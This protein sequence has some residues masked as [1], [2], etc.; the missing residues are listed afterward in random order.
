MKVATLFL[1]L[2]AR[3][4][5]I[6]EKPS[7]IQPDEATLQPPTSTTT[8]TEANA[9]VA[10]MHHATPTEACSTCASNGHDNCFAGLCSDGGGKYCWS[11]ENTTGFEQCESTAT[12]LAQAE[13]QSPEAKS[14]VVDSDTAAAVSTLLQSGLNVCPGEGPRYGDYK[15]NHD[16][17]HRVCAELK[18]DDGSKK[19]WGGRDFWQITGQSDWS[20]NVGSD[21]ANPGGDWCICMWAF[22]GIVEDVGCDNVHIDC[23][24]TDKAFVLAATS[25]GSRSISPGQDC[26]R[27]KCGGK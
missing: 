17:T 6:D 8:L 1:L 14:D 10:T 18:N 26:L 15:C 19:M 2:A 5:S 7:Q 21:S 16:G 27:S 3:G 13:Q 25:D 20:S 9:K 4:E 22:S 11:P 24:A 12:A 23:G